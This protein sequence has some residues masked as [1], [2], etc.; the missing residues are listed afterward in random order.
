MPPTFKKNAG[1]KTLYETVTNA[2]RGDAVLKGLVEF[3]AKEPNIRRA[4]Q[5]SGTWK[6]LIIYFLQ[7]EIT[8]TDVNTPD[9]K[10]VP[11]IVSYYARENELALND[12][13][14]RVIQ[15]L[16][17]DNGANLSKIGFIHV[18]E[19]RYDGELV[20]IDFDAELNAF[21]KQQRFMITFRKEG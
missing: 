16:D 4:I 21:V 10:R 5:P 17:S 11:L 2:L 13:G 3:T 15:L 12:M 19:S 20:G 6:K 1:S 7:P 14:E 9:I 18:Y 8:F